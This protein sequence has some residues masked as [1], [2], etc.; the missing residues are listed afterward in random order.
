[1]GKDSIEIAAMP[2]SADDWVDKA[3]DNNNDV[4]LDLIDAGLVE[5]LCVI[6]ENRV[7]YF[8]L[9]LLGLPE[10]LAGQV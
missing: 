10:P 4:D 2:E 5:S 7:S 1:M 3:N 6:L 8:L 9:C